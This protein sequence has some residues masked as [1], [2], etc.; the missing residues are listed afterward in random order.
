LERKEITQRALEKD[1]A[2]FL[3]DTQINLSF[4]F[5]FLLFIAAYAFVL[6]FKKSI[7]SLWRLND[8]MSVDA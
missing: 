2:I 3:G 6:S 7:L 8:G 5:S 1:K 4:F